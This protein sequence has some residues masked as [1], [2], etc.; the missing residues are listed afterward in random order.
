LPPPAGSG[1]AKGGSEQE[2][3]NTH[4]IILRPR[5]IHQIDLP[6]AYL[7]A[8]RRWVHHAHPQ[9]EREDRVRA[10]GGAVE[11]G[12][13]DGAAGGRRA[14]G[15]TLALL[16]TRG[17]EEGRGGEESGTSVQRREMMIKH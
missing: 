14:V 9:R 3:S 16:S 15:G 1:F 7:H 4:L 5:Q 10:R 17:W 6:L 8:A 13:A 12:R 11:E 2:P